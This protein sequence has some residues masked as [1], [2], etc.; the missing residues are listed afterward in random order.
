MCFLQLG[1]IEVFIMSDIIT[2]GHHVEVYAD[3]TKAIDELTFSV[4][5]TAVPKLV[6]NGFIPLF[7]LLTCS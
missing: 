5:R 2:V 4:V 1:L 6:K 3:G 7:A